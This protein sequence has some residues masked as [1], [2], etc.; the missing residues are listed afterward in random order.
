M[1]KDRDVLIRRFPIQPFCLM[2]FQTGPTGSINESTGEVRT[3]DIMLLMY[4][5][6]IQSA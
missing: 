1:S 3:V 5:P 6:D 2:V 4:S